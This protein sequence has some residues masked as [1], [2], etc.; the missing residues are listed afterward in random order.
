MEESFGGNQQRGC[1][2]VNEQQP[3]MRAQDTS[4]SPLNLGSLNPVKLYSGFL[5]A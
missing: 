4:M 3:L 5:L 1:G 2:V